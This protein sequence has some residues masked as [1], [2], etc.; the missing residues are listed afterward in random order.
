MIDKK[1]LEKLEY[2]RKCLINE[3]LKLTNKINIKNKQIQN[4]KN[5][6]KYKN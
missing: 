5:N 2:Q 1:R 3:L 6:I 4:L